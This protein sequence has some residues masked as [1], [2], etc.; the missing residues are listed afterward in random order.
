MGKVCVRCG[1]EVRLKAYDSGEGDVGFIFLCPHCGP[2]VEVR[3]TEKVEMQDDEAMMVRVRMDAVRHLERKVAALEAAGGM[4]GQVAAQMEARIEDLRDTINGQAMVLEGQAK[5]IHGLLGR[6]EQ[7]PTRDDLIEALATARTR[8]EAQDREKLELRNLAS[9]LQ[10]QVEFLSEEAR[11]LHGVIRKLIEKLPD[12]VLRSVPDQPQPLE[13]MVAT[14]P[15]SA[16]DED[17]P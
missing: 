6:P 7:V 3:D 17:Q 4:S 9:S 16:P 5:L 14:Q 13:P 1:R 2:N 10:E 8:L 12:D 11:S 15:P